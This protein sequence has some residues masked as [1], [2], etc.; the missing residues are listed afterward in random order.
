MKDV[1]RSHT[2]HRSRTHDKPG[3]VRNDKLPV[4]SVIIPALNE[5]R[6]IA[7]VIREAARVHPRT[8]IIVVTNGS[9]DGTDRIASRL[10]ATVIHSDQPLGHD[11]GRY[12]GAQRARGKVLLFIDGDMVISSSKLVPFIKAVLSGVDIALNDYDGP[13]HRIPV[14]RVILSKHALNVMLRR[15]DLKG[16]S[17]TTVPHAMSRRA[18]EE[19][20]A[21]SLSVPPLAQTIGASKGLK[22]KSVHSIP[23]GKLNPRRV[24][25]HT[26]DPLE[27]MIT[28]DH[29]EAINWLLIQ[30]GPR[31]GYSDLHRKREKV[32]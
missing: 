31:G 28:G 23:V 2:R 21:E 32:R 3:V 22:M 27:A 8:E 19:I 11:V 7:A 9:T 15:A 6:T 17:L 18:L 1:R 14:H 26:V 29:L 24:K 25:R 12:V 4:V 30:K 10:G 16:A 5:R 20:G 13:V